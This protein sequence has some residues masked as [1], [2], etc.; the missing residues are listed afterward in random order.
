[1]LNYKSVT[2]KINSILYI[3]TSIIFL[4]TSGYGSFSALTQRSLLLALTAPTVFLSLNKLYFKNETLTKILNVIF[5][6]LVLACNIYIMMVWKDR[7]LKTGETPIMDIIMG[8]ILVLLLLE[9]TRR[10]SGI[11][12]PII[13][14]AFI[15]YALFGPYFPTFISHRGETWQRLVN[16]LFVS[17]EGIYG[18]ALGVASTYI[19]I[20]VIFGAFL[21]QFGGGA[22]F[23]D[24]AY[25]IT[26]Q[27]RGGP[28]KTAVVASALFGMIS[29][30]PSANVATTGAF[31][32][33]LMKKIGYEPYYAGAVE[34]VASTGGM[35]TP[36][37]MGAMA[38]IMAD[39]LQIPYLLVCKAAIVPAGLYY[40]ALL[41]AVDARA[42]K[43][44]LLGLPKESLPKST[45]VI[46]KRGILGIPIIF[47]IV[48]IV[49]GRS[50]MK[51]A[52]FATLLT[53]VVAFFSKETRPSIRTIINSF[54]EGGKQSVSIVAIC[55]TA[56]IIVGVISLTGLGSKLSYTLISASGGNMYIAVFMAAIAS[57]ILGC[58][59][60]PIAVYIV[61][62]AT[63]VAP[64]T[65]L[66]VEPIS[67][68]MFLLIFSALGSITPPVALAAFVASG[69]AG[70]DANKT[71]FTA[72]RLGLAAYIIPFMFIASPS[73]MLIGSLQE[74]VINVLAT[75]LAVLCLVAATEGYLFRFWNIFSRILFGFASL[76]LFWPGLRTDLIGLACIVIAILITKLVN[77]ASISQTKT[78][79]T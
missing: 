77:K 39:Y 70:S 14:V 61:T 25:S 10:S 17:A 23:V 60:P 55:A 38:F 78:K 37:V 15:I 71:G 49:M 2:T 66:G 64:L 58:A 21:E 46:K 50:P 62:A 51:S 43:K 74:I 24:F 47:L 72:F 75:V 26:G 42:V 32:I 5:A 73:I 4:Y 29:G 1:M 56:G 22:F 35:F 6:V 57:L 40:F 65:Q 34:A 3:A 11:F 52:F 33:P 79:E 9:A 68:H 30:S 28:A 59:I 44:G 13:T 63:L 16:F 54:K 7:I 12:L 36:P 20:F 41:M 76:M 53:V 27:Y 45:D 18:S 69:I 8:A 67:S 31:T 19:V 48:F